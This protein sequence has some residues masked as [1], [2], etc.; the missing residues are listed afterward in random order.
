MNRLGKILTL[1]LLVVSC[2]FAQFEGELE[3]K[4]STTF[5]GKA[6]DE[7]FSML[8]KN[9]KMVFTRPQ[10][11]DI[12]KDTRVIYRQDKSMMW[13]VNDAK[14]SVMEISTKDM[15]NFAANAQGTHPEKVKFRKSGKTE[16]I[17][18]YSCD[19]WI[20]EGEQESKEVYVTT[21]LG[22]IYDGIVKTLK[23]M[24]AG[25]MEA[26]M[27]DFDVEMMKQKMF[28][29]KT[30]TRRDGS[31][32]SSQEVTK[33]E[34]KSVADSKFE[35]P[36]SYAKQSMSGEMGEAMKKMQDQM[37]AYQK[38]GKLT[39]EMQKMIEE[40][41]KHMQGGNKQGADS[42]NDKKDDNNR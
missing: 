1:T 24:S 8:V 40:Q 32:T 7:L 16:S 31:V 19:G 10:A 5:D 28:P 15:E 38:D 6:K 25:R 18:G 22:S 41:M 23:K 34:S 13:I 17:L 14:K 36:A 21:K 37:K 20:V 11:S 35:F 12:G 29:L 42:S 3:M 9:D 33:I 4:M 26:M 27:N 2:L 39:P 30:I